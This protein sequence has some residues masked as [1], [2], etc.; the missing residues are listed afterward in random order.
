MLVRWGIEKYEGKHIYVPHAIDSSE[1]GA[2][3]LNHV[4]TPVPVT[5]IHLIT[6]NTYITL[7]II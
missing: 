2:I 7:K 5:L 4:A 1:E 6:H 3:H